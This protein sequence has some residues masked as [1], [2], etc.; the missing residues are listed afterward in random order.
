MAKFVRNV[1]SAST[2]TLMK[3]VRTDPPAFKRD[4]PW[5]RLVRIPIIDEDTGVTVNRICQT[6]RGY[7]G[8]PA[9]T[10]RWQHVK[11]LAI[12]AYGKEDGTNI[13]IGL[14]PQSSDQALTTF[15]DA[16]DKNHRP[17][18]KLILP[19]TSTAHQATSTTNIVAFVAETV[20]FIDF[21][22]EFS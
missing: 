19:P 15:D 18:L 11:I 14:V 21:Y 2:A 20:D 9:N 12:T 5:K 13:E 6:E 10:V 22:C 17:A 1:V 8:L 16:G 7:Y 4:R 3:R